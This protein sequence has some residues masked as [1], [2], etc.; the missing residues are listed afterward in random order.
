M[1]W[2]V[3][4]IAAGIILFLWTGFTQNVIP[5]GI[6]SVNELRRKEDAER[7]GAAIASSTTNGMAL[8]TDGVTAFIAIKP[9]VYY[10][11]GRYFAIEF[12]T[13]LLAGAVLATVL[14]LT[15][16]LPNETRLVL[17]G[18]MALAGIASIDIQYWNWWGFSH[19]YTLGVA[20]NRLVGY[21]IAAAVL[22][23][24]IIR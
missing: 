8:I 17:V 10:N 21:L 3:G 18:L 24:F 6:R 7:V 11:M 15:L 13:Q 23:G 12:I 9:T 14:T 20:V 1:T 16:G 22:I 4:M 19:R 2:L 5:W